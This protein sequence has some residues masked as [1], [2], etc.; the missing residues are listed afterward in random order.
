MPIYMQPRQTSIGDS[1]GLRNGFP[2]G[3]PHKFL[4]E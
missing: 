1:L 2:L 3:I 4:L